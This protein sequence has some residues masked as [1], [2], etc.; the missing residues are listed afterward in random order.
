MK[1]STVFYILAHVIQIITLLSILV[2][3]DDN[4]KKGITFLVMYLNG[5]IACWFLS[6]YIQFRDMGH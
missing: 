6:K 4:L 3:S 5:Y 1:T 2:L